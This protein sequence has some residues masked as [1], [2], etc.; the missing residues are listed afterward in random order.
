MAHTNNK[1]RVG[2]PPFF[3]SSLRFLQGRVAMGLRCGLYNFVHSAQ[4]PVVYAFA[5]PALCK[6]RKGRAT[7][8][9]CP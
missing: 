7:L 2:H 6:L 1:E 9:V 8:F 5:V 4:N 3:R